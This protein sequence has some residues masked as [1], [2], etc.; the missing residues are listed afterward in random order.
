MINLNENF[1]EYIKIKKN[2]DL[3]TEINIQRCNNFSPVNV[4]PL[5]NLITE[6]DIKEIE[7]HENPR[8]NDYLHSVFDRKKREYNYEYS[9]KPLGWFCPNKNNSKEI[10]EAIL[11]IMNPSYIIKDDLKKI[12]AELT[13]NIY[14]HSGFTNGIIMGQYFLDVNEQEYAIFDNGNEMFNDS[15]NCEDFI[16]LIWNDD[17]LSDIVDIVTKK[18]NGN[19]L[20][21]SGNCCVEFSQV[22][23]ISKDIDFFKGN[24]VSFRL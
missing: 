20:F 8:I 4:V 21:V 2:Y 19:I 15:K 13:K 10:I 6:K 22:G 12:F 24:L 14:N 3:T 23:V 7:P 5:F 11:R 1:K 16:K 9:S 18:F 17:N